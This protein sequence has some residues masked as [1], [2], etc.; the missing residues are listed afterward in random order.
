[1]PSVSIEVKKRFGVYYTPQT[2]VK[3][4]LRHSLQH[5]I[6]AILQMAKEA[7]I[8]RDSL[9]FGLAFRRLSE[10]KVLDP[11]CG[12]G[13]FLVEALDMIEDG[14]NILR[15]TCKKNSFYLEDLEAGVCKNSIR[16]AGPQIALSNLF[17]VD[18]D[19][20]AIN[21]TIERLSRHLERKN[22]NNNSESVQITS[23]NLK[24][25]LALN[26]KA[27]NALK[28][29]PID[30]NARS[31][32]FGMWIKELAVQRAQICDSLFLWASE[33]H[34]H[35]DDVPLKQTIGEV[36]GAILKKTTLLS[37]QLENKNTISVSLAPNDLFVWELHFPE[38]FARENPGFDVVCGNPPYINLEA[39]KNSKM[40]HF[41]RT[42]SRWRIHYRGKGD[43]Q[44]YFLLLA[45]QLLREK[46]H[47]AMVTSRYWPE[48]RNADVLRRQ[49]RENTKLL[50]LIDLDEFV[51]FDASVHNLLLI[52]EKSRTKGIYNFKFQRID[53]PKLP[54]L[55]LLEKDQ[56]I[57]WL[58]LGS[59]EVFR[60]VDGPWQLLSSDKAEIIARIES[61]LKGPDACGFRLD[62]VAHIGEGIK[63]GNDAVFA[64]FEH[65]G[66]NCYRNRFDKCQNR[67]QFEEGLVRRVITSSK[68][69]L[70][71]YLKPE[72]AFILCAHKIGEEINRFPVAKSYLNRFIENLDTLSTVSKNSKPLGKR[73]A[74]TAE[75]K[76]PYDVVRY[77]E[78]IFGPWNNCRQRFDFPAKGVIFGR[79]RN[80]EACFGFSE[81]DLCCLTNTVAI[82][83][84]NIFGCGMRY[85]LAL[86]NSAVVDFYVRFGKRKK[87]GKMQEYRRSTLQDIPICILDVQDPDEKGIH[88]SI[89]AKAK[90][91]ER[92][93]KAMFAKSTG[94]K[95]LQE[96]YIRTEKELDNIFF[97]LYGLADVAEEIRHYL[98]EQS[99]LNQCL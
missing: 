26:F 73:Y 12:D 1:M 96:H 54:I 49:F 47:L 7:A 92:L 28:I 71:F 63:T 51:L 17:G 61:I 83:S 40:N 64:S 6:N 38:V 29:P 79:Y 59:R 16:S 94:C 62:E 46:G 87:K 43:I 69:I 11:A 18:I 2:V 30:W 98:K 25:A 67:Y 4:L 68:E 70:R 78:E 45:I 23:K 36:N 52:L 32:K 56:D 5:Q 8:R 99:K 21:S 19:A 81:R 10:I 89:V 15:S 48:N 76:T 57:D 53:D 37:E 14:Y 97:Q 50:M 80:N 13:A 72:K 65:V 58:Q 90:E 33:E 74:V 27:A 84:K 34:K 85:L 42:S 88:D 35:L 55:E 31:E 41:L 82:S 66:R 95:Q 91:L 60:N 3:F 24:Y 86:L 39:I 44:Y 9:H 75:N 22:R 77:N 93:Q 20:K